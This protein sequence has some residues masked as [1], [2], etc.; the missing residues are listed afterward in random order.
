MFAVSFSLLFVWID[1]GSDD[2][3]V[4]NNGAWSQH[5]T[6]TGESAWNMPSGLTKYH[7]LGPHTPAHK[8]AETSG[9]LSSVVNQRLQDDVRVRLGRERMGNPSG[10]SAAA[11]LPTTVQ[12]S[13]AQ[14]LFAPGA[15]PA[16]KPFVGSSH[17]V[18]RDSSN[19]S[20]PLSMGAVQAVNWHG[21]ANQAVQFQ[22]TEHPQS[23]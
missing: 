10:G 20:I 16:F 11:S 21:Q 2:D 9:Y 4:A 23:R 6:T 19:K 12:A 7:V 3:D 8:P 14:V 15:Y 13:A 1:Y 18:S 22:S 17:Y 5:A